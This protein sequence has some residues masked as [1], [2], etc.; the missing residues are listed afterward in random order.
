MFPANISLLAGKAPAPLTAAVGVA[1]E[2]DSMLP[3]P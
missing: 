2:K 1:I 3:V